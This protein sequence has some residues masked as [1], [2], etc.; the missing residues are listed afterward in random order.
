MRNLLACFL[1]I[2]TPAC[3]SMHHTPD[4]APAVPTVCTHPN[5]AWRNMPPDH[6]GVTDACVEISR[7]FG[8]DAF[9]IM[10][11]NTVMV[12]GHHSS[13]RICK[14]TPFGTCTVRLADKTFIMEIDLDI[15]DKGKPFPSISF[16]VRHEFMHILMWNLGTPGKV[17]HYWMAFHGYMNWGN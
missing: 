12:T 6:K 9:K 10:R 8:Q 5:I 17:H 1:I 11:G 16:V 4:V 7:I 15:A 13:P 3:S 2:L 14:D